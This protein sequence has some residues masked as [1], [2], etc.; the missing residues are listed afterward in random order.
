[1]QCMAAHKA[2]MTLVE[3]PKTA[4]TGLPVD[5][6][7]ERSIYVQL[8]NDSGYGGGWVPLASLK[9]VLHNIVKYLGILWSFYQLLDILRSTLKAD[10]ELVDYLFYDP[11][12]IVRV[13]GHVYEVSFPDLGEKN[14]ILIQLRM[15]GIIVENYNMYTLVQ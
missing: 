13:I 11:N 4:G 8:G 12:L 14:K 9:N 10:G 1:M 5:E 6:D 3:F 15:Q 2:R 7:E